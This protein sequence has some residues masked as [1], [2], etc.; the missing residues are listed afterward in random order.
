MRGG[1]VGSVAPIPI[2][3]EGNR[4]G[5]LMIEVESR[6]IALPVDVNAEMLRILSEIHDAFRAGECATCEA[7]SRYVNVGGDV[8][9]LRFDHD[10][11]CPIGQI[12]AI[13]ARAEGRK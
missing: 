13:I 4:V 3:V 5:E 8:V 12:P 11:D 7:H 2:A 1:W 6:P 9:V 10:R